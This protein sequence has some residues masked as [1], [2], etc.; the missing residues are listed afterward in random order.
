M[1]KS[2][3]LDIISNSESNPILIYVAIGCAARCM[4][5]DSDQKT[6]PE[7]DNQEYPLFLQTIKQN[8]PNTDL[9]IFMIDPMIE[10]V[11]FVISNNDG[12]T[13]KQNWNQLNNEVFF[14]DSENTTIYKIKE[15]V[16]LPYYQTN[17]ID[18]SFFFD[19]L[20]KY[21]I[22]QNWTVIVCQYTGIRLQT[23]YDYYE[24]QLYGHLDHIIYRLF[25]DDENQSSCM[26]DMKHIECQY[27]F[28]YQNN[29]IKI[30]NPFMYKKNYQIEFPEMILTTVD[31]N[32]KNIIVNHIMVFLSIQKN[33]IKQLLYN[34]QSVSRCLKL[35]TPLSQFTSELIKHTYLPNCQIDHQKFDKNIYS[36]LF[37]SLLNLYSELLIQYIFM[38][39]HESSSDI[40][41]DRINQIINEDNYNIFS[42]YVSDLYI[43]YSQLFI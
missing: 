37:G 13:I 10:D 25:T 9:H 19:K 39:H 36:D 14:N 29:M 1:I 40:V 4:F 28:K 26:L 18:Y 22:K 23:P 33:K 5:S 35:E 24:N 8:I 11:P 43:D 32:Q 42:K 17:G 15:E 3:Y 34:I 6:L 2:K 12:K 20:N 30:F 27:H 31:Q 38:M 41:F 7:S 16:S 21:A